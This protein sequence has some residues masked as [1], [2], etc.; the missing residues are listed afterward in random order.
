[1]PLAFSI[2]EGIAFG[3][4]TYVGLKAGIGKFKE[5]NLVTYVLAG[6]FLLHYLFGR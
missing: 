1:M 3:L 6:L 2:S 4:L 5:I